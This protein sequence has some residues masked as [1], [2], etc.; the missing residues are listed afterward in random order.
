M[1]QDEDSDED[2]DEDEGSGHGEG[3]AAPSPEMMGADNHRVGDGKEVAS[4][5]S[6]I[7][8]LITVLT[9]H[10]GLNENP[11]LQD[12]KEESKQDKK[13]RKDR[14]DRKDKK[15]RG[16]YPS[17]DEDEDG[18]GHD[19][20]SDQEVQSVSDV[21]RKCKVSLRSMLKK[22]YVAAATMRYSF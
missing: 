17:S 19:G 22:P 10:S 1:G 3:A 14:K 20:A 21:V 12:Q 7:A 16:A 4:P 15:K 18:S 13:D 2:E 8:I 5:A 9:L 11:D 6:S